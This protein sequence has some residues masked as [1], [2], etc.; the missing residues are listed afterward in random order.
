MRGSRVHWRTV[1]EW[2]VFAGLPLVLLASPQSAA[3]TPSVTVKVHAVPIAGFSHTGNTLGAGAALQVEYTISGTEYGGYP[4]PLDGISLELPRGLVVSPSGFPTCPQSTLEPTGKG[5]TGCPTGSS[6]G[7]LG[8]VASLVIPPSR[9]GRLKRSSN[10]STGQLVA[11]SSSSRVTNRNSWKRSGQ[12][13]TPA[14]S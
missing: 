11:L 10:H 7:P 9:P 4:L 12:L 3:A 8:A 13:S 6:A 2:L 5:P 14:G 1:C